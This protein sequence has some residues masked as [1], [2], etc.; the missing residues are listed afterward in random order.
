MPAGILVVTDAL[1]E[2]QEERSD[3]NHDYRFNQP[4]WWDPKGKQT[5]G[6]LSNGTRCAEI[7]AKFKRGTGGD[8][9]GDA[10]RIA[11]ATGESRLL[12]HCPDHKFTRP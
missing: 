6:S 9:G 7:A 3:E 8:A 4:C 11:S 12:Q 1:I 10:G 2:V 5:R